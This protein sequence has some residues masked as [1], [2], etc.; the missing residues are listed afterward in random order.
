MYVSLH[1]CM[2]HNTPFYMFH[3]DNMEHVTHKGSVWGLCLAKMTSHSEIF[4]RFLIKV[5]AMWNAS[6]VLK[7][8]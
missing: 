2:W 4:R 5:S 7:P 3:K 6:K 8:L 1:N